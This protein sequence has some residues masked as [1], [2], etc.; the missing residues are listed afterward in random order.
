MKTDGDFWSNLGKPSP[1]PIGSRIRLISMPDDPD[2]I[3]PGTCGTVDYYSNGA[4]LTVK[5]D[6]GRSLR[7]LVGID[8]YEVI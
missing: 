5:W 8:E 4:Q 3:P 7:L 1:V 2:P 6:N